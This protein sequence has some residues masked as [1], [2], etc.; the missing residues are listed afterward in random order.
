MVIVCHHVPV[1][2]MFSYRHYHAKN[3]IH[4]VLHVHK[5]VVLLVQTLF[6]HHQVVSLQILL[7]C[8]ISML[9]H[10]IVAV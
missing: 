7:V 3:A 1:G 10:Q 5:V 9:N 2:T 8:P 6:I 4:N